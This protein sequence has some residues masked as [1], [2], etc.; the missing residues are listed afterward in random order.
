[1]Q[2]ILTL[3]NQLKKIASEKGLSTADIAKKTG[4]NEEIVSA[5][6]EG[7]PLIPISHFVKIVEAIGCRLTVVG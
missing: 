3:S 1:M 4:L 2:D 5:V 6:L 7:Y